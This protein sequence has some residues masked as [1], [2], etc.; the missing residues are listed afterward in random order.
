MNEMVERVA[1]A[2][3]KAA[4]GPIEYDEDEWAN[5]LRDRV[6]YREYARAAIKAYG[7]PNVTMMEAFRSAMPGDLKE[8]FGDIDFDIAY[9][10]MID[11]SLKEGE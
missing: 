9:K 10:A 11:A 5:N 7:E 8:H 1:K 3:H 2:L 4:Y 6:A